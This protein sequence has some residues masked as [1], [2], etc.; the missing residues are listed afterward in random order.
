MAVTEQ[1]PKVF[2]MDNAPV[3][4]VLK[5]VMVAFPAVTE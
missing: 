3:Y 5:P 1:P 2:V 4:E